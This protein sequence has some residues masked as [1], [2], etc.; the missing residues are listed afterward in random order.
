[1]Q[2]APP[3]AQPQ[4]PAPAPTPPPPSPQ[5]PSPPPAPEPPQSPSPPSVPQPEPPTPPPA[6]GPPPAAAQSGGTIELNTVT[7]E[8]LR[9]EGLSVT[10]ATRLLAQRERL[11]RFNSVDDLDQVV[12]FP[13]D[14]LDDLKRRS[15]V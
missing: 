5:P 12:G 9:A 11:G 10:Q 2:G 1:V 4:P 8:Q 3:V 13:A 15:S 14:V 6:P 7:F